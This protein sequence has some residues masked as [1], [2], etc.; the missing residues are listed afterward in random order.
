MASIR[1][2]I[3]GL[4]RTLAWLDAY[5]DQVR[6]GVAAGLYQSGLEIMARSQEIVPVK[7]G[8][9]RASGTVLLPETDGNQVSVTLGYG[10]AATAYAERVH[11]DLLARHH[12]GQEAKYLERPLMDYQGEVVGNIVDAI[13]GAA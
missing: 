7:T 10:G 3:E 6:K 4:D 12:D 2:E 8:V 9:L 13:Q 11:E 5:A 1:L